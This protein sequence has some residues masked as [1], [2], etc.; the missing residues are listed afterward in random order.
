M[1]NIDVL[2]HNCVVLCFNVMS[3]LSH[4]EDECPPNFI[5]QTH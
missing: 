1:S 2:F 4:W 5:N 3:N